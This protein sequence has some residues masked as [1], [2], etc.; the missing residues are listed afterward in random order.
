MERWDLKPLESVGVLSFGMDREEA[1]KLL[2]D[3]FTVFRKNK[4]SKNTTDDYGKFHVYYTPDDKVEAVEFFEGVEIDLDGK[5]I[6]PIQTKEIEKALPG[7]EKDNS[8]YTSAEKSIGY[9]TNTVMAES[10]L[11]AGAGYFI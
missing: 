9:A 4:F 11:V 1:R 6:F 5:T 10:I 3:K 2:G 8:D 7:I